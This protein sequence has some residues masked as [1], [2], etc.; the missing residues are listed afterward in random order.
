MVLLINSDINN[1][2]HPNMLNTIYVISNMHLNYHLG[3][4]SS[5][6]SPLQRVPPLHEGVGSILGIHKICSK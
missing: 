2:F 4:R 5:G 3:I 6:H 1:I